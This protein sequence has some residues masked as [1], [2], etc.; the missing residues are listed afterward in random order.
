MTRFILHLS[1]FATHSNSSLCFII[2]R[3]ETEVI[4]EIVDQIVGSLNRQP[5]NVGKNI[6]GISVHLEKLKLMMNT[7]LNK[8]RVIGI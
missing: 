1:Y 7:E 4:S 3:Y 6:V 2:G 5:L 8:V